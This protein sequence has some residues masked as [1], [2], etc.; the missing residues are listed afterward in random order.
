MPA[1]DQG[2]NVLRLRIAAT[3]GRAQAVPG[4][5]WQN[6]LHIVRQH[7][8]TPGQPGP[9][10]GGSEQGKAGSRRETVL[11]CWFLTGCFNQCLDVIDERT[12][13]VD[14]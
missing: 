3:L 12:G 5:R 8:V 11:E 2:G 4:N 7:H 14:G 1:A 9:G 13:C 6:S 10:A